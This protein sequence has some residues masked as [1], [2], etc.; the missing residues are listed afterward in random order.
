MPEG[1]LPPASPR[2]FPPLSAIHTVAL[3]FDGVFTD[4]H[5]WVSQDG[6]ESVRCSRADGLAFDLVRGFQRRGQLPA[7]FFILSKMSSILS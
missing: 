6:H 2:P 5:V 3:D 7:E 4:N 1:P